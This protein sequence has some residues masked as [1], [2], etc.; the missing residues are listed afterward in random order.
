MDLL[1]QLI[2]KKIKIVVYLENIRL[3]VPYV[4]FRTEGYG[5]PYLLGTEIRT[6]MENPH[7]R[8]C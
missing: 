3:F 1:S 6:N 2:A 5:I 8:V 4:E 7:T